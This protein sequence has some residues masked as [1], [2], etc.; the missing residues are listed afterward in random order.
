MSEKLKQIDLQTM[1]LEDMGNCVEIHSE[2]G[3]KP[4]Y[5][6]CGTPINCKLK[7]YLFNCTNP[8]GGRTPDEFKSQLIIENQKKGERGRLIEGL[9][10]YVLLI[11]F[12]VPYGDQS[13]GIYV[14]WE[15][16]KHREF[17]FSAN[18]QVKLGPM[19]QTTEKKVVLYRKKSNGETVCIAKRK[20]L[21]EAIC[22]RL[23]EDVKILL[24][25]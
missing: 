11:G 16:K 23:N 13:D 1:F 18:L 22:R 9:N 8:P 17:A 12:A 5:L 21:I 7:V 20:N 10:E 6:T 15:T 2:E 14:I 19:L 4:L 24:E 3:K 25:E